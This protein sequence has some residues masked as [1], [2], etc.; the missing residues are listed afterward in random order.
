MKQAVVQPE[1]KHI[2]ELNELLMVR[3]SASQGCVDIRVLG[4]QTIFSEVLK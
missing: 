4:E 2:L 3:S 1:L